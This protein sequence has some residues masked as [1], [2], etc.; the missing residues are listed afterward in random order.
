[1]RM[2]IDALRLEAARFVDEYPQR[3]GERHW[4]R[5]PLLAA[6]TVDG[7]FG[8]LRVMAARDHWMP[9]EIL[10][11]ARTVLVLF[12]PFKPSLVEE[13][14]PGKFPCPD[15]GVAYE[16]TNDLIGKIMAHLR[17]LLEA[18]GFACALTPATHEPGREAVDAAM[19]ARWSHKH[20]G[21]LC[22]LGR[23][24]V[25]AQL[26]TPSGCS[27]RLGSLVTSA[28]LGDHHLV[29]EEELCLH[30]RG[31][32]CLRCVARCPV[33]AV[34]VERGI[35][36]ERCNGRLHFNK[37]NRLKLG[38]G[39]RTHGCAKCQGNLPCSLSAPDAALFKDRAAD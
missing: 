17:E 10:P 13:N 15:W 4:W 36:R 32:Q 24:G 19:A 9:E 38:L 14:H 37:D 34:T 25:N 18:S 8:Q 16:V 35:L 7:R 21:Y 39:E 6:G 12:L 27:G 23:F 2:T 26:I 1:M 22:G 29:L 33:K 3:Y 31:K 28:D 30:K 5:T 11:S 20:L